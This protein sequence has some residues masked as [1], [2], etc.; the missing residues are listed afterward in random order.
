MTDE[1][2]LLVRF[3]VWLGL[4]IIGLVLSGVT[5]FPLAWEVRILTQYVGPNTAVANFYPPLAAWIGTV[6]VGLQEI[7]AQQP[8]LFYGTDWLAF[9]HLVIAIAFWGPLREPVRNKWL[10]DFGMIACVLVIPLAMICGP[11][12]GIPFFWRLIDCSFGVVGIVPLLI[13]KHYIRRLEK[14]G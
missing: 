13:C 8:Y 1:K 3:R 2:A 6:D 7:Q 5:A 14:L 11:I 4:F 10:I 9:G 12:R